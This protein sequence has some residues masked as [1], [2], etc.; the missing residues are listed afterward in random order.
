MLRRIEL[1]LNFYR[2]SEFKNPEILITRGNKNFY[3]SIKT[4]I[5]GSI[6]SYSE[7][8]NVGKNWKN[9]QRFYLQDY[10]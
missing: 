9:S 5:Y 8:F 6:I 4:G 3:L 10:E 2:R 1:F 7:L